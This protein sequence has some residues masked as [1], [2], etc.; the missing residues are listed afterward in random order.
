[1][2]NLYRAHTRQNIISFAI[3]AALLGLVWCAYV[4]ACSYG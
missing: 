4:I 3:F 2:K 1:M